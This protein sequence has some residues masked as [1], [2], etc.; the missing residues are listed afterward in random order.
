ML[1]NISQTEAGPTTTRMKRILNPFRLKYV[2]IYGMRIILIFSFC[3]SAYGFSSDT[4]ERPM[5]KDLT[6]TQHFL[7]ADG[8]YWTFTDCDIRGKRSQCES[9][10]LQQQQQQQPV[11]NQTTEAETEHY[12]PDKNLFDI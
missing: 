6:V 9:V 8:H 4:I 7:S 3:S 10:S 1:G 5:C 2:C 11:C 12:F